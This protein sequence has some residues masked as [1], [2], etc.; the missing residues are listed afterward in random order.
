MNSVQLKEQ[1]IDR[2]YGIND[3]EYLKAIKKILDTRVV[4]EGTNE[5]YHLNGQQKEMIRIGR[6]Q[7]A[8]G[9]YI[10]N[11]ER[12]KEEDLWLNK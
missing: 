6:E 10:S 2:I 4:P 11:E 9:E 3:L 7:I 1:V 5:T 12:E 8:N